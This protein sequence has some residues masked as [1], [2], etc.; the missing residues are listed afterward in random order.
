MPKPS[1][2]MIRAALLY[3]GTGFTLGA[4][5]LTNKGLPID[6]LLWR[7]LPAHIEIVLIG[8]VLQLAMGVAF[9]ILPRFSAQPRYGSVRPIWIAFT[10]LNLGILT[11]IA[12]SWGGSLTGM[13]A[14]RMVELAA[15]A[16]FA[17]TLWR[18]VKPPGRD[19]AQPS[20]KQVPPV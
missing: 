10:A 15:V 20:M 13:A 16:L 5:L 1:V 9:W 11:V 6:P 4:L 3:F 8:W 2:W 18:R 19:E 17:V 7:L 14:G 12:A